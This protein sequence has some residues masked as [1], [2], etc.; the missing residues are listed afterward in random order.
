MCMYSKVFSQL[1]AQQLFDYELLRVE[2]EKFFS[3][4]L[5]DAYKEND[6]EMS[7]DFITADRKLKEKINSISDKSALIIFTIPSPFGSKTTTGKTMTHSVSVIVDRENNTLYLQEPC[8][9]EVNKNNEPCKFPVVLKEILERH[10][11]NFKIVEHEVNVQK[12]GENICHLAS[13]MRAKLFFDVNSYTSQRIVGAMVTRDKLIESWPAVMASINEKV[14]RQDYINFASFA[15]IA[16]VKLALMQKFNIDISQ[17]TLAHTDPYPPISASDPKFGQF[18]RL[19]FSLLNELKD[20]EKYL[21]LSHA[22]EFINARHRGQLTEYGKL[23]SCK[24]AEIIQGKLPKLL[25]SLE[26]KTEDK[27]ATHKLDPDLNAQS[28][29]AKEILKEIALLIRTMPE[30]SLPQYKSE[31]PKPSI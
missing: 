16:E 2:Y 26:E 25:I 3:I 30:P 27:K 17:F 10:F 28:E 4:I 1:T 5:I 11:P 7:F 20:N 23:L 18:Q 14:P 8:Y 24:I 29:V 12:R 21:F 15:F 19:T 9:G 13:L 31:E 22:L 6:L